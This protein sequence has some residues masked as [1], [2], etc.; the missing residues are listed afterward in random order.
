[1]CVWSLAVVSVGD[2]SDVSSRGWFRN[3][4]VS[5]HASFFFF[6]PF[7]FFRFSRSMVV[8][9][10][11]VVLVL[12]FPAPRVILDVIFT[13]FPD[14]IFLLDQFPCF[15]SFFLF[16]FFFFF[17]SAPFPCAP[18]HPCD[19]SSRGAQRWPL[20]RRYFY[21]LFPSHRF[22]YGSPPLPPSSGQIFF[23]A[24]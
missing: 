11:V 13:F 7:F 2:V 24:V 15:L 5:P 10:V 18:R 22:F 21:L 19:C 23:A 14:F 1:M 8:V 16:F 9:L 6:F 17:L 3:G 4:C 12:A 20:P